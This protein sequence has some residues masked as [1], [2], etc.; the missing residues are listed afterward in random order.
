[1][2]H[3]SLL[4]VFAIA[5]F[6]FAGCKKED[7]TEAENITKVVLHL[8]APGL[9]KEFEARETNGDGIWDSIDTIS[10]P[11]LT[12]DIDC[13]IHV[14]D[15]T[16]SPVADLSGEIEVEG[17]VHFFSFKVAGADLI[18]K[19]NDLDANGLPLNLET[20]WDAGDVSNG[21]VQIKLHHEPSD[22][23]AADPGGEIDF[24]VTFVLKIQ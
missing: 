1:M 3:T 12:G 9:D 21:T 8:T 15:E 16:Q 11:S 20:L 4:L 13:R 10:I 19:S 22:K 6:S 18:V 2:K 7:K 14:L 23:S 24:D 5:A 17:A